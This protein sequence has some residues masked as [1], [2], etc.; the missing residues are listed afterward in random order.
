MQDTEDIRQNKQ[1]G[2]CDTYV[3]ILLR[4]P[5]SKS[6]D[7]CYLGTLSLASNAMSPRNRIDTPGL[8]HPPH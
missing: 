8:Y 3:S 7:S 5:K 2:V 1:E 6:S 4:S